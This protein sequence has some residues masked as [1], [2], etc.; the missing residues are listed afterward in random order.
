MVPGDNNQPHPPANETEPGSR[1]LFF[2]FLFSNKNKNKNTTA[3]PNNT[4]GTAPPNKTNGTA[5]PPRNDSNMTLLPMC[6]NVTT[7]NCTPPHNRSEHNSTNPP[8]RNA[9]NGT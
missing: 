6:D 8:Y 3:A 7:T 1:V 9:S 4:N 2:D 5:P